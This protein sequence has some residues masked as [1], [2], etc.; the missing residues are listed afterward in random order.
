MQSTSLNNKK[1]YLWLSSSLLFFGTTVIHANSATAEEQN[2]SLYL[3]QIVNPSTARNY[4]NINELNRVAAWTKE[5][6]RLLNIPCHYQHYVV[7][8]LGYKNLICGIP[9][10]TIN[11]NKAEKII[12]G[13]HYDVHAGQ[14]GFNNNASG[15]AALIEA[16]R[17][18]KF[19]QKKIKSD[20]EIVFY[21]LDEAPYFKTEYMGSLVHAKSLKANKDKIKAVI[22]L[23]S[24]GS[25]RNDG[26]QN[27]PFGLS[28]FYPNQGN[29]IANVGSIGVINL[30]QHYCEQFQSNQKMGCETFWASLY[31]QDYEYSAYQSYRKYNF[32]T[33]LIT[34]TAAYRNPNYV[35]DHDDL[36]QLDL[37]K[38]T[39]V[40]N[41]LV[42]SVLWLGQ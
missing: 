20:I 18:I 5:Q 42:K 19:Q 39:A 36:S 14:Q 13:A 3:S 31:F 17:L 25:F 7:N 30:M 32:P 37:S 6:M 4:K 29:Y 15:V 22:V 35:Q 16:A 23:D 8:S 12:L 41:A 27:Y 11:Q 34:D 24:I 40:I 2:L 10:Q 38:M 26:M 9:A 21:T 28:W 33:I 1:A